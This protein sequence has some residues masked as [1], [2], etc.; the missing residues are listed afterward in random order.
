MSLQYEIVRV[1]VAGGIDT[2]TDD[3]LVINGRLIDLENGVFTKGTTISKRNGYT[4]LKNKDIAGTTISGGSALGQFKKELFRF[5]SSKLYT[6]ASSRGEF[7]NKGT[8]VSGHIEAEKVIRNDYQQTRPDMVI[9]NKIG[10][11]AWED[12]NNSNTIRCTVID[13]ATG[14]TIMSDTEVSTSGEKPC[15]VVIDEQFVVVYVDSATLKARK[16]DPDDLTTLEAEVTLVSDVGANK[17]WDMIQVGTSALIVYGDNASATAFAH[18]II[19]SG[20]PVIAT[21]TDDYPGKA[22][23]AV[24]PNDAIAILVERGDLEIYCAYWD[25]TDVKMF[26]VNR[27]NFAVNQ[28]DTAVETISN[29]KNIALGEDAGNDIHIFYEQSSG[30]TYNH[31]VRLTTFDTSG[32]SMGANADFKRSCGLASKTFYHDSLVYVHLIHDST[33][34]NTLFCVDEDGNVAGK[35]LTGNA[36]GVF[37]DAPLPQTVVDSD[38]TSKFHFA[39]L[40]KT[41]LEDADT[42]DK[43]GV[44]T[45]KGVVRLS[46]DF[47]NSRNFYS[48]ALG[49]TLHIGGGFLQMYDGATITEHGFHVYPE[50]VTTGS[51][52]ASG[53]NLADG[54]YGIRVIYE[55]QDNQGKVHRSNPSVAVSEVLAGG[56]SSQKFTVTIPTLRLTTKSLVVCEVY[57]T[58]KDGTVYYK[59]GTVNNSTTTDTVTLDIDSTLD[60]DTNVVSNEL[61]YTNGGVLGNHAPPAAS[62]MGDFKNRLVLVSAEQPD[63]FYFS[64][65]RTQYGPVEFNDFL[66]VQVKTGGEDG[67]EIT[68]IWE[69]DD[70]LIIF[71]E[72]RMMYISGDG[73]LNTGQQNT[74][75]Q[76]QLISSDVGCS[77]TRSIVLTP[78]G[79]MFKSNKG[80]YL[81]DR[82]MQTQYIGA[83]VESSNS[84]TITSA[85]LV[86]DSNQVR[87][88]TESSRALI[89]DYFFEKWSTAS[90]HEAKDAI[91]FQNNYYYMRSDG[92]IYKEESTVFTD[93][94]AEI[95]MKITTPW[96]R[97]MN[98]QGF[99]RVRKAIFLGEQKSTHTLRVRAF[100]DYQPSHIDS[101]S[102]NHTTALAGTNFGANAMGSGPMG[103]STLPNVYQVRVGLTRQKCE[104]IKFEIQDTSSDGEAYTLASLDLEIGFKP[105]LMRMINAQ[106]AAST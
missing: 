72:N 51:A 26:S 85:V 79:L 30:S 39:S 62:L 64:K 98:V 23:V 58:V 104:A 44:Y 92:E 54:T 34:Q 99:Q 49:E 102:Y 96:L 67:E 101:Y 93:N 66:T 11:F 50:N 42:T 9:Q 6:Y 17:T 63:T 61:L 56:G 27:S 13:L 16:V 14:S 80:V 32:S 55:W 106:T 105:H 52:S 89:Y 48:Q 57:R 33:L 91:M 22:T 2:K 103:G 53:G 4:A 18:V 3:K 87:F 38:N 47:S 36:G 35:Y 81:L 31:L 94:G 97:L 60:N 37:S 24:T 70:K 41:A 5:A 12:T 43:L 46:I 10:F 71:K 1:D 65:D 83:D 19:G 95:P 59:A 7:I 74:F 28:A 8:V 76:P 69:M 84:Q 73:P 82:N 86:Q 29:I 90:N 40:V 78:M 25:G 68:N 15:C 77:N 20:N 88:T 75:T 45:V 100:Y 21:S